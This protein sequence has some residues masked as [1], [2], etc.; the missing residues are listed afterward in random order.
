[1]RPLTAGELATQL[2]LQT[3]V[4]QA[5][6]GG[7]VA[8][9]ALAGAVS[10]AGGLGTVGIMA[11]PAFAAALALA[12]RLAG[13]RPVAA[14][15]LVPFVREAHVRACADERAALVVLHGGLGRRWIARLRERGLHVLVTV[16]TQREAEQALA[17]GASGVVAQGDEAGGHLLG[18]EPIERALPRILAAAGDAP[19]LAAG[20]VAHAHDVARLLAQGAAAVVAGTRFLLTEESAANDEYKRRVA[21][22]RSTIATDLFGVGWP[23]RHRVIANAATERWCERDPH[24]PAPLRAALRLSAPLGR[25][26]PLRAMS[27]L[28][29]LQRPALPLFTPA[30]PLA[31]MPEASVDRCALYAGET[32]TR[33]GDVLSAA[34]ALEQLAP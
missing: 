22:A 9:G 4:V 14:N 21:S 23:L 29:A 3:P 15:L 12:R 28:A 11:P 30:V 5:G 2:R 26:T 27:G 10:R 33:L 20:G 16:G 24:G 7:G 19:V 31:G 1:M 25:L 6:M 32:V 34:S 8:G 18:V 13:D 17:A